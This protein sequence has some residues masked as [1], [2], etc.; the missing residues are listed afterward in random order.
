[1][2]WKVL[3]CDWICGSMLSKHLMARVTSEE[4]EMAAV[5]E[6]TSPCRALRKICLLQEEGNE[7]RNGKAE[8]S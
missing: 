8:R 7:Q 5:S 1:M 4:V 3:G 6:V 2:L